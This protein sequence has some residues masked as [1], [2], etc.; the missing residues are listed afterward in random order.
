MV[1]KMNFK[2]V[3]KV[4]LHL[5]LDGSVDIKTV[6][7]LTGKSVKE[8]KEEMVAS[9]KCSNLNEYLTKFSLANDIMQTK[10]NIFRVTK[11]LITKLK[12]DNVIYAEV[13]FCP[14]FHFERR[15]YAGRSS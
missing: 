9:D 7:D 14:L 15:T 6:C 1:K 10:E 2:L 5:H 8:V 4:E 12:D 11:E 3:P 13:R